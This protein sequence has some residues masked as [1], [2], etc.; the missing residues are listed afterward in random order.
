M[1]ETEV[2]PE[3]WYDY[4]EDRH[5]WLDGRF[6]SVV[7]QLRRAQ[8]PLDQNL[9]AMDIGCGSGVFGLQLEKRTAWTVDGVD[10]NEKGLMRANQN[11]R[12]KV[13][14]YDIFQDHPEM[15]GKYDL[16]LMLDVLEHIGP[17]KEFL[18]AASKYLKPGGRLVI[19]VPALQILYSEFDRAGG[20]V[21]RYNKPL[22]RQQIE[23]SHFSL[24]RLSYWGLTMLPLLAIRKAMMA[25]VS[26]QEAAITL[27]FRPPILPVNWAL[28]LILK[29]E[30]L[31]LPSAPVG[32]S[33]IA[34]ARKR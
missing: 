32:S 9:L 14:A 19:N 26:E 23:E 31:L 8:I 22:L 6:E 20:H 28:K 29:L 5:F 10:V 13:F 27:G 2:F 3:N 11:R 17:T 4:A 15:L 33:I 25:F 34:I 1:A 30:R 16:V 24:E 12:G 18:D 7:Q 21:R